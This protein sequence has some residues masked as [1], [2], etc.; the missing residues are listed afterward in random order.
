MPFFGMGVLVQTLKKTASNLNAVDSSETSMDTIPSELYE[1]APANLESNRSERFDG[2]G[3]EVPSDHFVALDQVLLDN[4]YRAINGLPLLW[5]T[6]QHNPDYPSLEAY[7]QQSGG[8][9]LLDQ[10]HRLGEATR[11]TGNFTP[12]VRKAVHDIRGGGLTMFLGMAEL[13][14]MSPGNREMIRRC[15]DAARDHA[16]IMRNLLP[17]I[18]P[19]VRAADEATKA[20]WI[21]HFT[22]KW[23]NMAAQGPTGPVNVSVKCTFEGAISARC[24]ETSSI[25]RVVYNFVNNAVRFAAS[26]KVT[27]WVF[28][29]SDR[30]TRWVVQNTIVADQAEFLAQKAGPRLELLFAGGVTRGGTGVGMANCAEIVADCFGITSPAQAVRQG[31]IG[32]TT[33]DREFFSWFHWPSYAP[34]SAQA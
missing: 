32:A 16:K 25:D 21:D 24:L 22:S 19:V 2:S 7:I 11:L 4:I 33:H 29:V 1:F 23:D 34:A 10:V 20:H 31:Y 6:M 30:M 8:P 18:D 14:G 15:V 28:P 5:S 27:L 9:K 17:D 26:Q 13:L 12:T 3:Y